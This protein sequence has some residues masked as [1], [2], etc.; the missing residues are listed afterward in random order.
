MAMQNQPTTNRWTFNFEIHMKQII[1]YFEVRNAINVET[2][3]ILFDKLKL[4][5]N[6]TRTH[7]CFARATL[8][9]LVLPKLFQKTN[10]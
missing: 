2:G 1:M 6:T 9:N 10:K 7:L 8:K 5:K 4:N 3:D